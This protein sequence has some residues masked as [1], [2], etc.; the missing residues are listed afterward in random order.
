MDKIKLEILDV[1]PSHLQSG[2][3]TLVLAETPGE[4]KLPI[5]IGMSE[6]QAIAIEL[7]NVTPT[8]P[9]THDL[10]TNFARAF[11]YYVEEVQ[12][13]TISE[14]IFYTKII[15]TDGIRQKS[16]DARPSDAVAIA[17]KFKA[18]IYT[19]EKVLK[20]AGLTLGDLEAESEEIAQDIEVVDTNK[21][22][23]SLTEL[24]KELDKAIQNEEYEKAAKIRDQIEKR[25]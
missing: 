5:I 25:K 19:N 13:M 24:K 4:R 12:I 9:L 6:A 1:S 3:F 2:S 8:R 20:E 21:S 17:L 16:I 15:C 11:D 14:G 23:K 10:F 18:P 22:E 7:E